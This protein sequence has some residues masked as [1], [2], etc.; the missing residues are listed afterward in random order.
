[1]I[2]DGVI[3][4]KSLRIHEMAAQKGSRFGIRHPTVVP[5]N[6]D[7]PVSDD[8]DDPDRRPAYDLHE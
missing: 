2:M 6:F 3:R 5:V 8:D 7:G 4:P 1:M